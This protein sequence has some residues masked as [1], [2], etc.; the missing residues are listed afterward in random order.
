MHPR[1]DPD[2]DYRSEEEPHD[3]S[4][5]DE[6]SPQEIFDDW[7]VSLRRDQRQMLS[8][9]LMENFAIGST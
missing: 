4:S 7:M 2:F 8:V 1:D 9:I 3:S 6:F 5:D